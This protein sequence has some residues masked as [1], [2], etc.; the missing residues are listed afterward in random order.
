MALRASRGDESI[1]L[2]ASKCTMQT[3]P[4]RTRPPQVSCLLTENSNL[5]VANGCAN[6]ILATTMDP[7][8]PKEV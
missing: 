4:K 2:A 1:G 3:H 7:R 5:R 6:T 8:R